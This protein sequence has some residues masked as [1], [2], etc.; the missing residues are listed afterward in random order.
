MEDTRYFS[1]AWALLTR[2]KGWIKPLLVM[3]VAELV[4]IAG[5][6]GN[7]GY[8]L[9]WARLTAWGV[10]AAPK[11]RNVD[12]GGCI[13]S[14]WRGFVVE[15]GWGLCLG[16]IISFVS[17]FFAI[18]PGMLGAL[19]GGLFSLISIAISA[20]AGAVISIAQI[21]TA[22]YERIGAGYR[23]DRV[24]EMIK[25][26]VSGFGR[27][28]LVHLACG[29][30]AGFVGMIVGLICVAM[31]MPI[32]MVGA[33]G[34]SRDQVL[35][36]VAASMGLIFALTT[37]FVL[38]F[39]LLGNA[40]RMITTIATALWMRQFD[41]PSWGRSDEP[42]PGSPTAP[43]NQHGAQDDANDTMD[44]VPPVVPSGDSDRPAAPQAD[45]AWQAE[46]KT[47][48]EPKVGVNDS[49]VTTEPLV[50]RVPLREAPEPTQDAESTDSPAIQTHDQ[51]AVVE[52]LEPVAAERDVVKND[53]PVE[54]I[55]ASL[56]PEAAEKPVP[57]EQTTEPKA[58]S[59]PD[60]GEP[61]LK[62]VDELY[63]EL[64]DVIQRNNHVDD[65]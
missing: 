26:D 36:V 65:E 25:R 62:D 27:V 44:V 30:V 19:L 49:G 61:A 34:G 58:E 15:L 23:V 38:L 54:V 9:E 22:I 33:A 21:R 40:V 35:G 41:V 5:W 51:N 16:I 12:I 63:A 18:F 57:N 1:R 52:D 48:D 11:Q 13:A 31:L 7:K 42:L 4:P 53:E 20:V 2:D 28:F 60:S 64:Y 24:F 6:L 8:V 45:E 39:S 43:T 50:N 47:E 17:L 56:A 37:V 32:I 10:D 14:G 59:E 46:T 55:E 3:T 29:A